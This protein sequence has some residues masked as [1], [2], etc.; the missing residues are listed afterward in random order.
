VNH[1]QVE[2]FDNFF[3]NLKYFLDRLSP[4][5]GYLILC[6][7]GN[8]NVALNKKLIDYV[9]KTPKL[10]FVFQNER[11]DLTSYDGEKDPSIQSY[12]YPINKWTYRSS[13]YIT[14]VTVIK[15]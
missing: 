4:G 14:K 8:I 13:Q 1:K 7:R 6:D 3:I 15:S 2:K 5:D 9:E 10:S 11:L 12:I